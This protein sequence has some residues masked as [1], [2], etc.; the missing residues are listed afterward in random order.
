M[1]P[2]DKHFR[3]DV[4]QRAFTRIDHLKRH[5]LRRMCAPSCS[6]PCHTH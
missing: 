1:K 4:C 3:C 6:Y 5:S 2:T